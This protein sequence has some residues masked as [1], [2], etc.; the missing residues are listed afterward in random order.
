VQHVAIVVAGEAEMDEADTA[1]VEELPVGIVGID[2]DEAVLIE[3]EVTFDQRQGP[4]A[5]RS[6]ADHHDRALD[7]PVPRPV[8]HGVKSPLRTGDAKRLR[9]A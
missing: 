9:G 3:F 2:D 5:D 7:S 8:G 1:V 4:L 6:E